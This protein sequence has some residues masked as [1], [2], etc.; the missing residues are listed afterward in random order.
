L[1]DMETFKQPVWGGVF[2]LPAVASK[3]HGEIKKR[4]IELLR[5]PPRHV[6]PPPSFAEAKHLMELFS[7]EKMSFEYARLCYEELS[8]APHPHGVEWAERPGD[9][10]LS[11]YHAT[12]IGAGLSG[13]AVAVLLEHLGIPYTIIE[14]EPSIGGTWWIHKFPECRVDINAFSYQYKFEKH[15]PWSQHY[16]EAA[17]TLKYVRHVVEKHGITSHLRLN[18]RLLGAT[19][20]EEAGKWDV[21]IA[22]ADGKEEIL[23]SNFV[24]NAT[25]QFSRPKLPNVE[26]IED[27]DGK[28]FHA[29]K[30]DTSYSLKGKR[31]AL[32]GTGATGTQ[33]MPGLAA[34]GVESLTVYQRTPQWIVSTDKYKE[35]VTEKEHYLLENIPYYWNWYCYSTF[36]TTQEF[37]RITFIDPDWVAKGGIVSERN[38][39]VRQIMTDYILNKTKSNPALAEKLIPPY[40]PMA[41]RAIVDNGWYD[42]L[43]QDNVELVTDKILRFTPRGIVSA[44]GRER[45][46]D[47][48]VNATGFSISDYFADT[49]YVGR[50]GRTPDDIWAKDGARAYLSLMIPSLPNLFI[51]YG[52]N[53]TPRVG[54]LYTWI[55]CW[56]RYSVNIARHLIEKNLHSVAVTEGAYDGYNE[57]V[58]AAQ[59][60]NLRG[61]RKYSGSYYVNE[62]GRAGTNMPFKAEEWHA[63]LYQPDF[64]HFDIR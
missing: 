7:G 9:E 39:R 42:A 22:G 63:M 3:H 58:D 51:F 8:F 49:E 15:Y 33:M 27:F 47:L 24:F 4:A 61:S 57:K 60:L 13:I 40:P 35:N 30:W 5:N 10:V 20:D 38:D 6:P 18:T 19:W 29:S 28:M 1:A 37:E 23:Q 64:T 2:S 11:T 55:E 48:V 62:F 53:A 41:R 56:A 43:A 46:F 12:I 21:R 36:A 31:V 52:P 14:R 54:G 26:G 45:E 59:K 25:G 17:E 16:P 44:D 50:D 34:A 32:V